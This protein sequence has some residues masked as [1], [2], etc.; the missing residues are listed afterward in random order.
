MIIKKYNLFESKKDKFPNIKKLNI[1]D[2]IV[3]VGMDAKS[4]DHLTFNIADSNDFWFH[5]KGVPGSHVVLHIKDKLPTETI[6]KTVG[7]ITKKHSKAKN[8]GK[9]KI[10]Y[11]KRRFVKKETGMNDG[12]VRVDYINSHEIVV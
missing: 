5:V 4:N 11:C 10:V 9:V 7:E 6:L 12:Q 1:D 8:M 2:F 3:Y